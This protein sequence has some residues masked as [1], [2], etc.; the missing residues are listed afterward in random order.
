VLSNSERSQFDVISRALAVDPYI[1]AVSRAAERRA[2]RRRFW[3]WL[4]PV[5][6]ARRE[7]RYVRRLLTGG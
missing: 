4:A 6:V 3:R 5:V 1:V 2:R 7:R